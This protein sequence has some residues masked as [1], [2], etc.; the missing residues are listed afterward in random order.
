MKLATREIVREID[1]ASIEEYGITGLIL[2]ENAGRAVANVL[3]QEFPQAKRVAIF[4]GGGNNGGDGF[5]V[6]RHLIGEGLD[7]TTYVL[8]DPKKY[9]GDALTNYQSL[10]KIGGLLVENKGTLSEYK[11]ADVIIDAIFGTGLDREVE[12][13]YKE[14]IEFINRQPVPRVS[15]D[16]PSGLDA[17]T[18]YPLGLSVKA[19]VTVTF[20]LPKLGL[21]IY[22]GIEYAGKVYVV[23]ITTPKFLEKD[24]PYELITYDTVRKIL[25][26]RQP[27][28]HKGT[29]GHLFVLS[30][31]PGKTGAATLV[32]EGAL[33]VGTG[34]VTVGVPRSLNPIL[35]EKLTEA[36]TEPLPE[37]KDSTF[38]KESVEAALRIMSSRKT[39]L[40]IGPGISTTEDTAHFFYQILGRS[41]LPTVV[42]ADGITLIA[43]NLD[44]LKDLKAPI[45][46]TP[47]P[48]EM[49]RLIG[50]TTEDIQKDRIGVARDF[51]SM[52]NVFT[53]LKGAR[54]VVSTPDGRVFINP[55]GNPGMAS[56]GMGDVL[57][58]I[59]GGFLAQG[60]SPEYAC[61]LGVFSHGL[62][63]DL[64]A[65]KRGQAGIIAG[66]V[67]DS[68]PQTLKTILHGQREQFFHRIR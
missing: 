54:T 28:T 31:S 49:S 17:N 16:L 21:S 7:V 64:A 34:L 66:D 18:G 10:R 46:L 1:R 63:G 8:S 67:A 55:T 3:L 52:Y 19:D 13:F 56:G 36:M 4:A 50:K 9:K 27:N 61:I 32:A 40:A 6:A 53:V 51:S 44:I 38:G 60:Y 57:T 43:Q 58:G 5:V 25:K 11:Q 30:G 59:I 42:D 14:A 22:P 41:T 65:D 2:M 15:V 68:L 26:P 29:F 45:I 62:A 33:R 37:A 20:V 24:I 12:G 23:D 39:A 35:E 48:G 47:H